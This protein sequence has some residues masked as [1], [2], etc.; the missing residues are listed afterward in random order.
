MQLGII[1]DLRP[2]ISS[3]KASRRA[4]RPQKITASER[5]TRATQKVGALQTAARLRDLS[6]LST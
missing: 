6:W 2:S 5:A 4:T 1:L 3:V